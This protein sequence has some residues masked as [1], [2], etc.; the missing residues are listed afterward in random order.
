MAIFLWDRHSTI[1]GDHIPLLVEWISTPEFGPVAGIDVYVGN[2]TITFSAG[3]V[4]PAG[5]TSAGGGYAADP[6]NTLKVR[7][8]DEFGRTISGQAAQIGYHGVAKFFLGPAQFQLASNDGALSYVR[9]VTKTISAG[10]GVDFGPLPGSLGAGSKCGSRFAYS[11]P[12]WARYRATCPPPRRRPGGS[13]VAITGE[14]PNF[15]D[16]N[17]NSIPDGCGSVAG[18]L[19][20][21][22][23]SG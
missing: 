20:N 8:A 2:S 23:S 19:C 5:V 7:H 15:V 10:Q 21:W 3:D 14:P 1:A 9:A 22:R 6:S 13:E 4:L 12:I 16:G 17:S 11:N 18:P